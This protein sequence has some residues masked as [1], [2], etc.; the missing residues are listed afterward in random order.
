MTMQNGEAGTSG[1]QLVDRCDRCNWPLAATVEDGCVPGNCSQRPLPPTQAERTAER[2]RQLRAQGDL[3]ELVTE[4]H[5]AFGQPVLSKPTVPSLERCDLRERLVSEE[6]GE[7]IG[8]LDINYDFVGEEGD[9]VVDSCGAK[10]PEVAKEL[11]DLFYVLMGTALEF[12]IDMG[13]VLTE[14]HRSN[15]TKLGPDGKPVYDAHG[16][17]TKGPNYEPPD[18]ERVLQAQGWEP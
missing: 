15:M 12:G 14:V 18:I 6:Y 7:V 10:L 17:V 13:P 2:R 8:A 4:F 3:R 11:A 16:K 1:A 5:E 9:V